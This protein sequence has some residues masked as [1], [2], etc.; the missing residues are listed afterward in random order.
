MADLGPLTPLYRVT[1]GS[2]KRGARLRLGMQVLTLSL[3]LQNCSF[4]LQASMA[5]VWILCG[6][7]FSS[8]GPPLPVLRW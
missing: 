3:D 8:L 1:T 6:L 5:L 7:Q 4:C 2:G